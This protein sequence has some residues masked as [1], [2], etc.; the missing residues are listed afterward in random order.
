MPRPKWADPVARAFFDAWID[1]AEMPDEMRDE[2]IA[3]FQKCWQTFEWDAFQRALQGEQE[4]DRMCA[5]FAL[6]YL[7]P[8]GVEELLIPFLSSPVRKERWASAIALGEHRDERAIPFLKTCLLEKMEYVPS[9]QVQETHKILSDAIEKDPDKSSLSIYWEHME[10]PLFAHAMEE[11]QNYQAE[12][13]WHTIHRLTITNLLGDWRDP[14]AIPTLRLAFQKCWEIEQRGE[15]AGGSWELW[16]NVED[17]L[18]YALGQL[19]VWDALDGLAMP[20]ARFKLARMYLVFGAL[21]VNLQG[22]YGGNIMR[23]IAS[24]A[25]DQDAVLRMLQEHFGLDQALAGAN[26]RMFQQWYKERAQTYLQR[27]PQA[28][29]ERNKE[30]RLHPWE[31]WRDEHDTFDLFLDSDDDLP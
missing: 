14:R 9:Q 8:A 24:G 26:L 20:P 1:D 25:M 6:G 4:D 31:Q 7:A 30:S 18:A 15:V 5:L 12:H 13:Y 2:R 29:S 28:L 11:A 10:D 23:L 22:M 16:F 21:E 19:H 17:D 3:A 27:F